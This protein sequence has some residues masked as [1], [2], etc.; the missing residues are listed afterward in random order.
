MR[1]LII[2]AE[3]RSHLHWEEPKRLTLEELKVGIELCRQYMHV[4]RRELR[5]A[6]LAGPTMFFIWQ[7]I[8]HGVLK[9]K[10][11]YNVHQLRP[12]DELNA[13]IANYK[14]DMTA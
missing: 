11:P 2:P 5:V 4:H 3:W 7:L 12:D 1:L 14:E 13:L 6:E 9:R 8:R 10:G